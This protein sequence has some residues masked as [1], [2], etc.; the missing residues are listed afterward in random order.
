M[1]IERLLKPRSIAVFGGGVAEELVRQ[2]DR[3]GY[4]GEIWPVHPKKDEIRGR[5][6]YRSVEDL[7]GSPDAAYVGVN[8]HL[9]IDV[10][11]DLAARDAGAHLPCYQFR[12]DGR[13]RRE[14]LI[15]AVSA[16]PAGD[17]K[18]EGTFIGPMISEQDSILLGI[19]LS[20]K[21]L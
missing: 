16:L 11:R 2:C 4:Q 14:R 17:P 13:D 15:A 3:M 10:V 8:R 9:T 18:D 19:S 6:V 20:F 7:P 1:T 21:Y 5:K 12:A